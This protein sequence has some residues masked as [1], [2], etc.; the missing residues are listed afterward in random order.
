MQFLINQVVKFKHIHH[1]NSHLVVERFP[2]TTIEQDCLTIIVQTS[3]SEVFFDFCFTRTVEYRC[4]KCDSLLVFKPILSVHHRLHLLWTTYL[5]SSCIFHQE[6][7]CLFSLSTFLDVSFSFTPNPR[8]P[9]VSSVPVP[10]SYEMVP[11]AGWVRCQ[12]VYRLLDMACSQSASRDT[13]P[14][15]SCRPTILSPTCFTLDGYV[16]DNP[17]VIR[18][19][20]HHL[21]QDVQSFFVRAFRYGLFTTVSTMSQM[22]G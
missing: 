10:H 6:L 19:A 20:D 12:L 15:L 16:D 1:P 8:V 9:Q 3:Q 22:Y 18:V 14:L 21:F 13:T 11:P 7:T 4:C 5:Q 17:P 2:G